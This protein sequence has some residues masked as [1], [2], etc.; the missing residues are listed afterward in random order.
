MNVIDPLAQSFYVEPQSG[1]YVTS[2]DLY[3]Y[4]KDE[5]LPVTV[6]LRSMELGLPTT[7]VYPFSEVVIDS[8]DVNI[9]EDASVPTKVTFPSPVYLIGERFHSVVLLSN[10][11]KYKVWV[12]KLGEFDISTA[13]GVESDNILVTK[14]PL[15]GG[16][17]KSQNGSTWNESPY[18]DLKFTLYR[19]NFTEN[20]GNISFYSPELSEGN[21]QI[22]SLIKNP[23]EMDSKLIR[24][25]LGTTVQDPNLV[26]GNT[27][28]Q[29]NSNATGNYVGSA[30]SATGT[31]NIINAG[32]GYT[33]SSG[34]YVFN[35]V[36]LESLTGNGKNATVNIA[37][38]NGV[39]LGATISSGGNGYS[40]GDVLTANQVGSE[41]LGRNLQLSLVDISGINELVLDGV[42]GDFNVGAGSTLLLTNS[43]GF[44]TALN[45][46]VGGNVTIP[47]D[48]IVTVNDGLHIKVNHKNHGMHSVVNSVVISNAL[49]D[50]KF[51]KLSSAYDMT[52]EF[53]TECIP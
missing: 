19:A 52:T 15:T 34:Y 42:Q 50:V 8:K 5:N 9:S 22:A 36:S 35:N 41:S 10:S 45:S 40:I 32:I 46:S 30:G 11:D 29:Q 49:P 31:L 23:F 17:F 25:G 1:F 2:I 3:F 39:A 18:E 21:N 12:S 44:T 51:T 4:S 13:S 6:Q 53:T 43:L 48:G 33:P 37:I 16:L 27:I 26:I 7:L 24:V 47:S 38:E 20:N 28:S 14:Q